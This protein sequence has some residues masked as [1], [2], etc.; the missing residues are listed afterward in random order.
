M[1]GTCLL[2]DGTD[3]LRMAGCDENEVEI[4]PSLLDEIFELLTRD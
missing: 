4:A 3:K 1:L 2:K